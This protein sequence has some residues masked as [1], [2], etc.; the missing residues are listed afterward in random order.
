MTCFIHFLHVPRKMSAYHKYTSNR[1]TWGQTFFMQGSSPYTHEYM[2]ERY[3]YHI[4]QYYTIIYFYR[5]K[6]DDLAPREKQYS[7]SPKGEVNIASGGDLNQRN[8][9]GK[10]KIIVLLHAFY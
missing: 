2:M 10:S 5:G 3:R 4:N 8:Y 6:Y 9:R 7:L 1:L